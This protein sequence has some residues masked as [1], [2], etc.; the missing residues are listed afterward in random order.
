M[1]VTLT[2]NMSDCVIKILIADDHKLVLKS[3][4]ALLNREPDMQVVGTAVNGREAVEL[5]KEI[6]PDIIVMDVSMPEL[7]GIRATYEIQSLDL[8]SQ[9]IILSMHYN[10]TL[11]Q[12]A[13]KHGASGYV[14]K[15]KATSELIPS[16]RAAHDGLLSLQ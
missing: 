2:V 6:E 8:T 5:A 4:T 9:V 11:V 15:Q 14:L 13:R 12:Q 1:S 7:D 16:I 3:L 10:S